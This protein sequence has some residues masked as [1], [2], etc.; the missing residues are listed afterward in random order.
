MKISVIGAGNVGASA[1]NAIMLR[2]I[3]DE[4]ALVDIFGN[5]ALAKSMDL[6]QSAAV[7]DMDVKISGGDDFSLI[8]DSA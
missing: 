8:K 5:V 1:A 3:A 4:I 6:A 7:F 2:G